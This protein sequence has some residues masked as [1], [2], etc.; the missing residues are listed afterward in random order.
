[1]PQPSETP[2]QRNVRLLSRSI[3]PFVDNY[4]GTSLY[5]FIDLGPKANRSITQSYVAEVYAVETAIRSQTPVRLNS[6]APANTVYT[7]PS[8]LIPSG[9]SRIKA[10]AAEIASRE[11]YPFGKAQKIYE[12]LISSVGIQAAP[13]SGGALEALE[14]KQ[15]DS[16]RAAMLFCALAR[17]LEIPA[18]PVAGVLINRQR[19]AARHY[20][21][22]FWIDGFGWVPL[23]PALGAGVAPPDFNLRDDRDLYYFGNL[24]N[25][26]IIFSRGERMLS[27]MAPRGRTA[28][29]SRDYSLQN[30]W[31]EA[32]GGIESYSSL[33]S[34]VTITG[35]YAQ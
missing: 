22:E 27:Q 3:E 35:V 13:L 5:Q 30:L 16:Y 21:A 8:E 10:M 1:M 28:M 23:D 29:R 11:R 34:N 15:A 4:R 26:R 6:P 24:D 25:Q 17:A 18:L 33:W 19:A 12:W 31:E 20:W 9:D 2:S 7:L 32:D 14:E